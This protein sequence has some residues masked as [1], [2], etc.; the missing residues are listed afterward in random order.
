MPRACDRLAGASVAPPSPK[1]P[2][3]PAA[4]AAGALSQ[5]PWPTLAVEGVL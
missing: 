5:T 2:T 4:G 1:G 3:Q